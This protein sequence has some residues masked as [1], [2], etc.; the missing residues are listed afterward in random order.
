MVQG[1][2]QDILGLFSGILN[3]NIRQFKRIDGEWGT[4]NKE[5]GE[6][7]GMISNFQNGE[8]DMITTT[9]NICCKRTQAVDFL[10][11]MSTLNLGFAIKRLYLKFKKALK[12]IIRKSSIFQFR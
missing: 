3:F 2:F 6:W 8:A 10:W 4:L 12:T 7:N 1:E 9:I 5:T 11:P